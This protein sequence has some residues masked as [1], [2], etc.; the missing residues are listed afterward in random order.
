MAYL[1][2]SAKRAGVLGD[3]DAPQLLEAENL[4]QLKPQKPYRA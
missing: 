1:V 4:K 3:L 2:T